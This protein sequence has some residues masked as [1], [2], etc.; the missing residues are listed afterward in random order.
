MEAV[1]VTQ[2]VEKPF[3]L[4]PEDIE[5]LQ[6]AES[7]LDM[8]LILGETGTLETGDGRLVNGGLSLFVFEKR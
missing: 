7:R 5:L 2:L 1:N 3:E 4:S 6:R 8:D